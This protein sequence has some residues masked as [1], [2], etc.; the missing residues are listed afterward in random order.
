ME[1]IAVPVDV[2]MEGS[3]PAEVLPPQEFL[4]GVTCKMPKNGVH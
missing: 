3:I 2:L 4:I 1:E